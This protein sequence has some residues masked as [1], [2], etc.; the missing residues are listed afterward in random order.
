MAKTENNLNRKGVNDKNSAKEAFNT[1][2]VK[3]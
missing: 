1:T 3:G 2:M